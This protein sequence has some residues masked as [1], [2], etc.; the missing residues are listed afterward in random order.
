LFG[1][2]T[3]DETM[4]VALDRLLEVRDPLA[5]ALGLPD[6]ADAE[7]RIEVL[8]ASLAQRTGV[9]DFRDKYIAELSTGSRRIV[10]IACQLGLE[11]KVLLFD[12]PSSGIAQRETEALG[13]MLRRI[14]DTTGASLIVIEHDMPLIASVSD[15][16]IALDLG[17]VVCDGGVRTVLNHPEVVASYLGTS[18]EVIARSGDVAERRPSP[19]KRPARTRPLKAR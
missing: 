17:R 9:S 4:K 2:L 3:A 14:R 7:R 5:A 18:P 12:E 19:P 11:P 16:L 13:P 8:A 10:D 1:A 6:V 15:R